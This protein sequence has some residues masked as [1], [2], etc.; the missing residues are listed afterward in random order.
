[1][2]CSSSSKQVLSP[3][4]YDPSLDPAIRQLLDQQSEIQAKLAILIPQKYG[5]NVGVELSMLRHKLRVLE[6][7]ALENREPPRSFLSASV[8]VS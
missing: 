7:Y 5:S 4:A 8:R 6:T 2:S 3:G 1:V